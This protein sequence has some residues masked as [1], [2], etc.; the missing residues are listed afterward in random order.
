MAWHAT[1]SVRDRIFSALPYIFPL[2]SATVSFGVYALQLLPVLGAFLLPLLLPVYYLYSIPFADFLIFLALFMLVV[3]NPRVSYFV[4]YNTMQSIL[5]GI[6]LFLFSLIQRVIGMAPGLDL[7]TQV[8]ANVIFLGTLGVIGFAIVQCF[9]GI[10]AE[11]P[12]IS[13]A[14][15]SQLS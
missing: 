13:E 6:V 15:K 1:A 8:F 2:F 12:T 11:F 7:A 9:R 10:Y 3:R 4:R 5:I 14:A